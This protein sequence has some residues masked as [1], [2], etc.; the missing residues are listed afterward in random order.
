MIRL[1][2]ICLCWA[3]TTTSRAVNKTGRAFSN[4]SVVAETINEDSQLALIERMELWFPTAR[5]RLKKPTETKVFTRLSRQYLRIQGIRL[6]RFKALDQDFGPP[7]ASSL[8]TA[9]GSN[10]SASG[11]SVSGNGTTSRKERLNNDLPNDQLI[12]RG[13]I[14]GSNKGTTATLMPNSTR[15]RNNIVVVGPDS[16]IQDST[17]NILRV[18]VQVQ[19]WNVREIRPLLQDNWNSYIELLMIGLDMVF[20]DDVVPPVV[21]PLVPLESSNTTSSISSSSDDHGRRYW[22][23]MGLA[24]GMSLAALAMVVAVRRSGRHGHIWRHH[25]MLDEEKGSGVENNKNRPQK[26][27][28]D[29]EE[30]STS[31]KIDTLDHVDDEN[32]DDDDEGNEQSSAGET[33]SSLGDGGPSVYFDHPPFSPEDYV[34]VQT[35][36]GGPNNAERLPA[37]T[38]PPPRPQ[39]LPIQHPPPDGSDDDN[40]SS[41]GVMIWI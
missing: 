13:G 25:R 26:D 11:G 3:S 4:A 28:D 40:R 9:S 8:S 14:G 37:P 38:T 16:T 35:H 5:R 41:S 33:F 22:T 24:M 6:K 10:T 17:S 23:M 30:M 27:D 12:T 36:Q 19:A 15:A 20:D 1:L 7:P 31:P 34:V 32:G 39:E 29:D 18:L 2:F 21:V